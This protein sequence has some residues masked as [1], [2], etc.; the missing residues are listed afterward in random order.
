MRGIEQ[1]KTVDSSTAARV[2][3]ELRDT[4]GVRDIRLSLTE[5]GERLLERLGTHWLTRVAV[6]LQLAYPTNALELELVPVE[7]QPIPPGQDLRTKTGRAKVDS[8]KSVGRLTITPQDAVRGAEVVRPVHL[9][10]QALLDE[11]GDFHFLPPT[12]IKGKVIGRTYKEIYSRAPLLLDRW[13]QNQNT[14]RVKSRLKLRPLAAWASSTGTPRFNGTDGPPAYWIAMHWLE[15]GGAES[16][17]FQAAE[18][19]RDAGYEVVITADVPAAQLLLD[20]ALAITPHVY[21]PANTLAEQDWHSFFV[22]LLDTHNIRALHIHHST[23]A[24]DFLPALRHLAD[25]VYVLD[26]THIIEHRT[27]GFVR[28]SVNSSPYLDE[29]HVI[30]PHLRDT[31]I[32]AAGIPRAKVSYHPLTSTEPVQKR[33]AAQSN[34]SL[35]IGFLGRLAPQKRPFLFVELCRRLHRRDPGLFSFVMQGSGPLGPLTENQ[36]HRSGLDSVIERRPWGPTD[37]FLADIDV[38]VICSDNEGLTLTSLEA[39]RQGVLVLSPDVG[40]Q[41]TVIAE[42][43]LVSRPPD[44]FLAQ[45]EAA[46]RTLVTEPGAYERAAAAQKRLSD[47]LRAV[48]PSTS[49]LRDRLK[50]LKGSN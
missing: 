17:A 49:Y 15:S 44:K 37:D 14:R 32:L 35:R 27:G 50:S 40:S 29:H 16:W 26:T 18:L 24:Y 47:A 8:T 2:V 48:V 46:L 36:I 38:L 34:D 5:D 25:D 9:P 41:R 22:G 45:A 33:P 13:R 42:D 4:T 3:A 28:R 20:K 23:R 10:S 6:C 21:V 39:E 11:T 43:M 30:S 19:A 12:S 1:H 7:L 31:Y